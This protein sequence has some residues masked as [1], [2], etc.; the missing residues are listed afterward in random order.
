MLQLQISAAERAEILAYLRSLYAG[1]FTD[2][3]IEAHLENHVG[4]AAA[5]YATAVTVPRLNAGSRLLDVG[6]GFGS[7]VLA[8]RESGLDAIGVEPSRFEVQFARRRLG[9]V[10]PEDDP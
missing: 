3:A 2:A 6:S 4:F 7:C 8:A 10:R 1:V 9:H 5:D